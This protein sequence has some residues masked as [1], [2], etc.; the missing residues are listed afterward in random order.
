MIAESD[1]TQQLRDL[2]GRE[3]DARREEGR[4]RVL[5]PFEYPDGDGIVVCVE[6]SVDGRYVVSDGGAADA[7]LVGRLG[8]RALGAPAA[9]IARR[10]DATFTGGRVTTTVEEE[11]DVADA[12]RRVAL[13]A[14]AVAEAATYLRPHRPKQLEL[15]DGRPTSGRMSPGC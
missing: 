7:T 4:L 6:S 11:A 3:V 13:A 14:A 10:L 2:L 9:Q 5:T 1:I 12:C 8:S 15:V